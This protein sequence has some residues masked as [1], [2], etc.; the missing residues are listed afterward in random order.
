MPFVQIG[1]RLGDDEVAFFDRRQEIDLVGDLAVVDLAVRRFHEAVLVGA[2]KQRERIDQADVRAFRRLDRADAAIVR[3]MHVAHLEAGALAR[4]AAGSQG[5]DA[6]LVGDLRQRIGLVHELRQ[7][8]GSE[9]LL[10]RRR[11]RLGVDQVVRHQVVRFRLRQALLH[12]ALDAHQARPELVLGQFAHRTHAPVAEVIDIVDLAPAVPEFDQDADDCEDVLVRQRHRPGKFAPA[13]AAVEFHAAHGRQVVALFGVE[14]AVEQRL[15]RLFRGRLAR[16][17]HAVDGDPRRELVGGLVDTQGLRNVRPLVQ[18]VGVNGLNARGLG[19]L[20]LGQH[21]LGDLVVGVAQDLAGLGIDD[22]VREHAPEQEVVGYGDFLDPRRFH[23][24]DVLD[25]DALVLGYDHLVV[26]VED[27][28]LGGL[29]AQAFRHQFELDALLAEV[30][31]IE[32]EKFL[33]HLLRRQADRLQQD[34][35]RHLAPAVDA[36]IQ[37]ILGIELEVEPGAAV[38]DDARREQQLARAVRLAAVV[39]EEHARRAVQ[40]A[41]DDALGTVDDERAGGGHERDLAHVDLLLLHFLDRGLARFLV[42][43]GQA[44]L[45]AQRA[46]KGEAALLAL[47]D[48]E[49]RLAQREADEFQTR[50]LR[51]AL[52]RENRG[53]SRLQPFV[54]ALLRRHRR[55]QERGE[56]IELRGEQERHVQ[57]GCAFGEALADTLFLGRGVSNGSGGHNS[58]SSGC[59][60]QN[61]EVR[62][63]KTGISDA[64]YHQFDLSLQASAQLDRQFSKRQRA[65]S[66]NARLPARLP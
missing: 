27:V 42:H 6:A 52:D 8:A 43:D 58:S 47:L 63:H 46:G 36:E 7:L 23:V 20:Q 65:G 21:G 12:R 24:A 22:V 37:V 18:I 14:Q 25:R 34:G 10:D 64:K 31:G 48:V 19:F 3:R 26:L 66:P 13:D 41:D 61:S 1:V 55:L 59:R 35:H 30:E 38:G 39:L 56:G 33:Q 16:A 11:N 62:G 9:E 50:V 2:R 54:L 53:E 60:S 49:R 45:G 51:M 4:Q 32:G 28:E 29:A 5:R 44:H 15:H 17:H 57:H 40:L